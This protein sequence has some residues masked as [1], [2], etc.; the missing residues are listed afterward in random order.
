MK[1]DYSL[2]IAFAYKFHL[3]DYEE[4][5]CKYFFICLGLQALTTCLG[6]STNQQCHVACHALL[7]DLSTVIFNWPYLFMTIFICL[8]I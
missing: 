4:L 8:I 5:Y 2:I 7:K 6:T 3:K 1:F